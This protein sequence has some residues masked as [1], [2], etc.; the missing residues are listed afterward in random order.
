MY[1]FGARIA[2]DS[3]DAVSVDALFDYA[4]SEATSLSADAGLT[5]ADSDRDSL[6]FVEW[7]VGG[8]HDFGPVGVRASLGQWGDRDEFSSDNA[9]AGLFR[10]FGRWRVSAGYLWRDFDLTFRAL[11]DATQSRSATARA[12]GVDINVL[13]TGESG[14]SLFVDAS[15]LDYNRDVARL[16][17]LSIARLLSPSSLTL[18]GNLLDHSLSAG[19]EWPIGER[20]LSLTLS[21]DRTAVEQ[22]DVDSLLINWL[23][24][25][26]DRSDIDIGVGVSRDD[27]DTQYFLSVLFLRYGGI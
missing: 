8:E 21:R 12:T 20:A 19:A 23:M 24:P 6:E 2:A 11:T 4:F 3:A 25:I 17:Q 5:R 22:T 7:G 16:G 1:V 13:Y 9:S 15:R 27:D 10:D 26:G 18:S 14:Y